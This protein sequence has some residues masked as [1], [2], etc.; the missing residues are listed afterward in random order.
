VNNEKRKTN[1]P[2]TVSG[3]YAEASACLRVAASA[4]AGASVRRQASLPKTV[5]AQA[6]T[7]AH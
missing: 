5:S 3:A 6:G 4:K 1:L 7:L 2:K